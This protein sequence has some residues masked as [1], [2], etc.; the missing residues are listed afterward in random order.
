MSMML[1]L[2][3]WTRER[4]AKDGRYLQDG[5]QIFPLNFY[6]EIFEDPFF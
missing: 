4:N 1:L 6:T 3:D 5:V 2:D